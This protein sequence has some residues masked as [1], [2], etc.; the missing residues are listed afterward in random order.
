MKGMTVELNEKFH[1]LCNNKIAELSVYEKN[2]NMML[3]FHKME[4][5]G[6]PT[7]KDGHVPLLDWQWDAKVPPSMLNLWEVDYGRKSK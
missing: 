4:T 2:G 7:K 3:G 1:I 5:G 6:Q